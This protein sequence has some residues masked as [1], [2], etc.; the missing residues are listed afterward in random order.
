MIFKV[1]NSYYDSITKEVE[2][3]HFYILKLFYLNY[4]HFIFYIVLY[5]KIL[6]LGSNFLKSIHIYEF[7]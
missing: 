7:Y 5:L 2:F 1:L 4:F 3:Y 6:F